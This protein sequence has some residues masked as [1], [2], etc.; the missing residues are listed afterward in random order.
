M[1]IL[2]LPCQQ[3]SRGLGVPIRTDVAA[4][5]QGTNGGHP[6]ACGHR[7]YAKVCS[8]TGKSSHIVSDGRYGDIPSIQFPA[9]YALALSLEEHVHGNWVIPVDSVGVDTTHAP[10]PGA[11]RMAGRHW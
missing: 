3:R 5:G 11:G 6:S 7:R 1:P 10:A 2:N 8:G 4:T 9:I